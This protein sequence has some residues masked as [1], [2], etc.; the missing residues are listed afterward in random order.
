[1]EITLEKIELVKDRTGVS[2]KEAKE[3]LEKVDGSVVDAIILIEE[4]FE[5]DQDDG[6]NNRSKVTM[7]KIKA[8]VKSGNVS[9]ILIKKN[10]ETLL[11][12]PVNVGIVGTILAPWAAIAGVIAAFG[13]KCVIEVVK[14]SGEIIDVSERANDTIGGV[15]EKGVV[16][17]DEVKEKGCDVINNVVDKAQDAFSK[18]RK[19]QNFEQEEDEEPGFNEFTG[20]K[21]TDA[22]DDEKNDGSEEK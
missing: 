6:G 2:Y 19:T 20:D 21:F 7:D 10:G 13:T 9:K 5:S 18:T 12:L 15:M 1:M 3:A 16:I 11:N 17:A 4:G 22:D 8:A 14:T